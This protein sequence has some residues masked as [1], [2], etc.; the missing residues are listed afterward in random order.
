MP[1][2][3][4]ADLISRALQSCIHQ[5]YKNL[6]VIVFDDAS[7]DNT[8]EVVKSFSACDARIKLI[9]NDDRLGFTRSMSA[10]LQHAS[11]EFVQL[12][13]HD[14]W[15]AQNYIEKTLRVFRDH[16]EAG[17]VAG[18]IIHMWEKEK[19]I[20]YLNEPEIAAGA[21][22]IDFY[23]RNAC[24]TFVPSVVTLGLIRRE[25][26]LR[27]ALFVRKFLDNIPESLPE[28]LREMMKYEYCSDVLFPSKALARQKRFV[29]LDEAAYLKE[30]QPMV[31]YMAHKGSMKL[32]AEYGL[33]DNTAKK[34]FKY[35]YFRRRLY[36]YLFTEDWPD[37]FSYMRKFYGREVI[38]T[39]I[40]KFLRRPLDLGFWRG[41]GWKDI[42]LFFKDF[43][44]WEILSSAFLFPLRFFERLF[45][46]L[47]RV[48]FPRSKPDIRRQ[49]YFLD[50]EGHFNVDGV[51]AG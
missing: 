49:E 38:A 23:P 26:A 37:Y 41:L 39:V 1:I 45:D 15:L 24:K 31:H 14:D 5:T 32:R 10:A 40:I 6:E 19:V 16:P 27:A 13:N 34:F 20:N 48:I 44:L 46:W 11:G 17:V 43:S 9:S 21:Y 30:E 47:K 36:E 22:P 8:I 18:R 42:E 33:L 12:L 2:R 35:L 3:N 29:L 25:D 28:E 4:A 50:K 51:A 7:T